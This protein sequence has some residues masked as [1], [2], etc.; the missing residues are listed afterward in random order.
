MQYKK[1]RLIVFLLIIISPLGVILPEL[2]KNNGTWGEWGNDELYRMIG[3]LPHGINKLSSSWSSVFP[4]YSL[5]STQHGL[6]GKSIEYY[7]SAVIGAVCCFSLS[8]FL[9]KRMNGNVK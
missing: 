9:L 5:T 7:T 1:L 3:Y 4:D 6:V 2:I 8:L